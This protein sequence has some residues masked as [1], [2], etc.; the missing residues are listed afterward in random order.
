MTFE[1]IT[2]NVEA[3]QARQV[4]RWKGKINIDKI[5]KIRANR[6]QLLEDVLNQMIN[7]RAL[8]TASGVQLDGIGEFYGAQ[9]ARGNR[10]DDE[11]RAFLQVLPA[12]LRQAGQHEILIQALVNLTGASKIETDYFWPR[13]MAL[14]ALVPDVDAL[15]N[16]SDINREMQA[17]RAQGIR[18]DI[19]LK[20]A[21]GSFVFSSSPSGGV[22]SG[23][24]F[25][26]LADGSD[27]GKFIK[28]IG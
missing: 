3:A 20:Q 11:Y 13:A 22:P 15:T 4:Q 21:S 25:A 23:S 17:I 26:T 10:S 8:S 12:K 1:P 19:G 9:G 16:E 24:G 18:L 2:D 7:Q 14:Y 27:G 28:K 5:L 6:I